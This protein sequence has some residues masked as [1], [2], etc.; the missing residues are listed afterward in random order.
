MLDLFVCQYLSKVPSTVDRNEYI[1]TIM[2]SDCILANLVLK[3]LVLPTHSEN[4]RFYSMNGCV[5][6]KPFKMVSVMAR[7]IQ[8]VLKASLTL[9]KERRNLLIETGDWAKIPESITLMDHV[10]I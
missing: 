2:L 5:K 7:N 10:K 6:Q 3:L 1:G 4:H 8:G 9:S